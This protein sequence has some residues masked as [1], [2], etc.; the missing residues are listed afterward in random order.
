MKTVFRCLA[1]S[2]LLAPA[3]VFAHEPPAPDTSKAD[4]LMAYD[5]VAKKV[6]DLAQAIPGEKYAWRPAEGVRSIGEAVQHIAGGCYFF[7]GMIGAT[8]PADIKPEELEKVTTKPEVI[9]S[10]D[11]SLN[12]CRALAEQATPEM[13]TKEIDFFGQKTNGRGLFLRLYGHDS[14]HLG[15]LISYAR[16]IG[17]KP[18]WSQ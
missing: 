12:F 17:I 6:R 7:S 5:D 15:Q 11:R 18:P 8:A 2:F 13:L 3:A 14:E 4:F 1:L 9:A 16:S 10:V